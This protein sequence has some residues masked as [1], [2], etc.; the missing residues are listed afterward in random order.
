MK[1]MNVYFSMPVVED[2]SFK[3][4]HSTEDT[5]DYRGE[6]SWVK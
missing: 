3:E 4:F 5:N 2:I 1:K 6:A